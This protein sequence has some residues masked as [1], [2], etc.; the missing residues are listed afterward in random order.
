MGLIH[1]GDDKNAGGAS[2]MDLPGPIHQP[3][4]SSEWRGPPQ[5]PCQTRQA[6][7]RAAVDQLPFPLGREA[8]LG[9]QKGTAVGAEGRSGP[10][11]Q[12]AVVFCGPQLDPTGFGRAVALRLGAG[13]GDNHPKRTDTV[14]LPPATSC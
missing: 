5:Q 4:R 3:G 6:A 7:G 11:Q 14:R 13:Q 8:P 10:I 1:L 12:V 9:E 2:S